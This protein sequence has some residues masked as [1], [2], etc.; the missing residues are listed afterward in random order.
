[1]KEIPIIN[2]RSLKPFD[3]QQALAGKPVQTRDGRKVSN[4]IV[5]EG[6][7]G[8]EYL[9]GVPDGNNAPMI[10]YV[11]G[12]VHT[13]E[14]RADLFMSPEPVTVYVNVTGSFISQP[15]ETIEEAKYAAGT[16]RSICAITIVDGEI[17]ECKTVF[18][19]Q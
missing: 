13:G 11:N 14:H 15:Y 3:L 8:A 12:T 5:Y 19:Y 6:P 16:A 2:Q 4:L 17:T 18:K 1:M 9:I 10:W 7:T